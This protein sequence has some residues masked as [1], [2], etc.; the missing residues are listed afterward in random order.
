LKKIILNNK[1]ELIPSDLAYFGGKYSFLER[2]KMDGIGSPKVIYEKGIPYFDELTELAENE[3]SFVNFEIMKNG[4]LLHCN[5]NQRLR[6]VGF[7]MDEIVKI[8]LF[9]LVEKIGGVSSVLQ[10]KTKKDGTLGFKVVIQSFRRIQ[11][12]FKKKRLKE[13]FEIHYKE[14]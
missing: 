1:G 5:R 3:T 4:F 14:N 6:S 13:K 11:I 8:D 9:G 12:F 2:F 10:I 7:Q